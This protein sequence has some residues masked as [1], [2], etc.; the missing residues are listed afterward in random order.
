MH[1]CDYVLCFFVLLRGCLRTACV[2]LRTSAVSWLGHSHNNAT[3]RIDT[4]LQRHAIPVGQC[5][6]GK[7][8]TR[9]QHTCVCCCGGSLLL[10][11]FGLR[12]HA[13][14]LLLVLV[15]NAQPKSSKHCKDANPLHHGNG[16]WR[17]NDG[18]QDGPE[19][20]ARRKPTNSQH[21]HPASTT[22]SFTHRVMQIVVVT[23]VPNSEM[24]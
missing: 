19:L 1:Q 4:Q 12:D 24:L 2:S 20:A 23:R 17:S 7:P 8:P 14:L 21:V 18:D 5:A 22:D 15:Q 9:A 11:C 13:R 10:G 6:H 16:A 3:H